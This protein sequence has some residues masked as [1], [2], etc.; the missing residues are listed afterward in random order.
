MSQLQAAYAATI[1]A[2]IRREGEWHNL[3]YGYHLGYGARRLAVLALEPLVHGFKEVTETMEA[4]PDYKEATELL[5]QARR[6][7]D[8]AFEDLLR[9]AQIMGQTTFTDA[10]KVDPLF[11]QACESE[12]GRGVGYKSR[13]SGRNQ[14]WFC[15]TP[16]QEL[17]R[18]LWNVVMREWASAMKRLSSLLETDVSA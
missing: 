3:S 10:L 16:R 12:W 8:T 17:E 14:V 7:L 6:V 1:R 13:V 11:W 5:Q 18:E 2:S 15:A 9:R 4:N